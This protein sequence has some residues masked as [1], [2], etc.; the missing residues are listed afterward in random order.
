[1][2]FTCNIFIETTFSCKLCGKKF[3][4]EIE[5]TNRKYYRHLLF[6]HPIYTVKGIV[7]I[8]NNEENDNEKK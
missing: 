2:K 8:L 6:K 7:K 5:K 3:N 1:M 4:G